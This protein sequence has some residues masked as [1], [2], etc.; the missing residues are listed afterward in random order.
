MMNFSVDEEKFESLFIIHA[1]IIYNFNC[2]K[3][4]QL[5]H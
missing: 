3:E 2:D 4:N 5:I 1:L